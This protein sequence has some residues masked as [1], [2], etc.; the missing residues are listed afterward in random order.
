MRPAPVTGSVPPMLGLGGRIRAC[1]FDMDGVLTQTAAVHAAAWKEMFDAYLEERARRSG[2]AAQPFDPVDDYESFVD[3]RPR[4]DGTRAFLA[5]RGV[6]L[7]EGA[8]GDL[9]TAETV[10][11]LSSRKDAIFR[12]RLATE[13]VRPYEGSIRYVTAARDAG[14]RRAVVT[15]SAHAHDILGSAGITGLFEAVVDGLVIRREGLPGKPAP[16]SFLAAARRLDVAPD[17]AA[18]FDDGPAGVAAGRAGGFGLVVGVDRGGEAEAL[19]DHGAHIVVSDLAD[20]V[21]RP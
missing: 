6:R 7:P 16:D 2:G 13:G 17:A 5:S 21:D 12:R 11:G 10:H 14:L 15:A 8:P 20:L 18:V 9:P 1:L 3:G 19:R 4:D